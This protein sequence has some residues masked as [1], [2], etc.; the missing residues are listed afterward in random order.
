MRAQQEDKK[1]IFYRQRYLRVFAVK[2]TDNCS[3]ISSGDKAFIPVGEPDHAISIGVSAYNASLARS[4]PNGPTLQI[5]IICKFIH[6]S[7]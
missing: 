7:I 3:F 5:C 6:R 1:N 2:F 4:D